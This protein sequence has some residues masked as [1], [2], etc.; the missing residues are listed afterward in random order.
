MEIIEISQTEITKQHSM[1]GGFDTKCKIYIE[2]QRK[3]NAKINNIPSA[4]IV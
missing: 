4:I 1:K 2:L 3:I